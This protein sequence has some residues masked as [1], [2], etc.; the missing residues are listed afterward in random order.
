MLRGEKVGLRARHEADIAIL[1]A[2]L[3]NDV[4][5]HVRADTRPWQPISPGSSASMF[6]IKE[7]VEKVALFSVVDLASDELAGEAVLWSIDTHNR[8]AHIGMALRPTYRGR[9]LGRDAVAV[10]CYYAFDIRGLHRLQIETLTDN[11]AMINIATKN[12][13]VREGTLRQSGWINGEFLDDA[14]FGLLRDEWKLHD[15]WK[16][17]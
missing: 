7:P 8:S 11:H 12:G 15:T 13:F 5:E 14:L 9:G 10:L 17:S 16:R 3:Y 2:E 4:A 6:A 1:D